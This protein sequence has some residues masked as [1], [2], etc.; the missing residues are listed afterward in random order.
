MQFP[1][2]NLSERNKLYLLSLLVGLGSGFAAVLLDFVIRLIRDL[3]TSGFS[4]VS[5][6]W[7]Y[8]VYPGAGMLISYLLVRSVDDAW[9]VGTEVQKAVAH[10]K[11]KLLGDFYAFAF[12]QWRHQW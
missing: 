8:F 1:F 11:A 3:L 2:K 5:S 10:L 9:L 7:L 12:R 4:A 6:N